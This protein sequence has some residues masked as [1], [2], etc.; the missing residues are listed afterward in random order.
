MIGRSFRALFASLAF[1]AVN[2]VLADEVPTD[3]P[4]LTARPQGINSG[5]ALTALDEKAAFT[6]SQSAIGKPVGDFVL[7]D[8]EGRPVDLARYRGKPLLV[9]F[10]YTACFQVCPTTTRNLQK[11]V[12]NTVGMIGAERFNVISIG[13]NQPFDSPAAL[14]DFAKQYGIHLPN[15]EFLSPAPA[16]VGDLTRNFGFSFVAT[17]AGFDHLN[18]VTMVDAEGRIVRQVYGEKFTAEDLAEPLKGL[19]TGSAIPAEVG[20][21][22][23]IMERVRIICSI[24]DPVTGRYRTNYSL[25]FQIAGFLTFVGFMIY[26]SINFWK[27]RRRSESKAP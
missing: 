11:A 24:Y 23:E 12:Q 9:S 27:N 19:I 16:I 17:P 5:L 22:K 14:R 21:L 13:F 4:R 26:L 15:W 3:K 8:R 20:T 10:I 18:Q 2:P 6:L 7:L 25:Y 1:L